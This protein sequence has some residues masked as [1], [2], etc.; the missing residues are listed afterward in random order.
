[1]AL[2]HT[3]NNYAP[4]WYGVFCFIILHSLFSEVLVFTI[5]DVIIFLFVHY[6]SINLYYLIATVTLDNL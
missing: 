5:L 3:D 6:C 1:M 4:Y 2:F